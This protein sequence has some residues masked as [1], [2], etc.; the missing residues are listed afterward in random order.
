[1]RANAKEK[2]IAVTYEIPNDKVE[3]IIRIDSNENVVEEI[4]F[5]MST[6]KYHT[7]QR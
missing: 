2:N 5:G 6:N 1:M 4:N 7:T 3:D